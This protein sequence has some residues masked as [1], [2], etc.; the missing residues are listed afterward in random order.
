MSHSRTDDDDLQERIRAEAYLSWQA[1]GSP[2]GRDLEHWEHARR[3]VHVADQVQA[4]DTAEQTVYEGGF[5]ALPPR[6]TRYA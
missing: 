1:A 3:S 6:I 2:A 5:S 4:A